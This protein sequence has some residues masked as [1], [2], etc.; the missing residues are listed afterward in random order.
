MERKL[1]R[2]KY[3]LV[4][5]PR[6]ELQEGIVMDY[7]TQ[8]KIMEMFIESPGEEIKTGRIPEDDL[9]QERR[10]KKGKSGKRINNNNVDIMEYPNG[11]KY[12]GE[13]NDD[14]RD[15]DGTDRM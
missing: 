8:P 7:T 12:D 1:V 14:L 5:L 15:G 3:N 10:A 11:D 9:I 2:K 6:E 13:W 4:P